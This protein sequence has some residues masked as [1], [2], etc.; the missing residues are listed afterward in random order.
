MDVVCGVCGQRNPQHRRFCSA[1]SRYL[2]ENS[3]LVPSEDERADRPEAYDDQEPFAASK[4]TAQETLPGT[5][6]SDPGA[7]PHTSAGSGLTTSRCPRCATENRTHLRF[8]RKCGHFLADTSASTALAAPPQP[9]SRSWWQRL[10]DRFR[11]D[12]SSDARA[13]YRRSLPLRYRLLRWGAVVVS[14]LVAIAIPLLAMRGGSS[15]L[16]RLF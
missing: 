10:K 6:T 5:R 14:V 3:Q 15:W 16:H 2:D 9:V 12:G 4:G 11:H 7:R 1:C 8:C 13:A